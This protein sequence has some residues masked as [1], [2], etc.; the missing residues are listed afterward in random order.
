MV[1][2]QDNSNM[3]Q[4]EDLLNLVADIAEDIKSIKIK[5][6]STDEIIIVKA[7]KDS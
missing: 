4:N 3:S 7:L 1:L 5:N 6:V 2:R